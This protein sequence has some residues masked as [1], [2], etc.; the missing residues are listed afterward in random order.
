MKKIDL[1]QDWYVYKRDDAFSLVTSIP[2]D[3]VLTD[4]PYDALFHDEQRADSLNGGRTGYFDSGVYYYQKEI[5]LEEDWIG[6]RLLLKAEG[7]FSKS[8]VYVNGSLAG[9]GDFG[10]VSKLC[11]ITDYVIKGKNRLLVVTKTDPYSSRW[12]CGTGILRPLYLLVGEEV[13]TVPDSL[14]VKTESISDE[15]VQIRVTADFRKDS[16]GAVIRDVQLKIF[17][18]EGCLL[19]ET[20]PVRVSGT[21]HLDRRFFL[22]KARLYDEADPHLYT[23]KLAEGDDETVLKT[24][25]RL[26]SFDAVHGLC[27]NHK[28]VKLRGACIHHDEGILGGIALKAFEYYRVSR[29]KEAGFNAIR[30][31]HNHPSQELL[32]VCDELGVYV[33]DEVCDMWTKMK[34]F[35]DYAQYFQESWQDTVDTMVKEDR[36]HPCVVGYS[37]GNEISDLNTEKGFETAHDLYERIHRLDDTRFVTNGINGAFAAG[38]QL[39]DIAVDLT[40]MERSVFESGD[41]NQFLGLMASRM[42]DI[43]THPVVTRVVERMDSCVDVQGYNYMT[44]RY[45]GDAERYTN[46]VMLGTETYPRQ[47]AEN[48]KWISSLPAVIG[49][50][51]WTGWDYMGELSEPYPAINNKAG[52][53]D[54]FGYRRPVSYY[55]EIVYGLRKDPY[56]AVRPPEAYGKPRQFGPWKFTDAEENWLFDIADGQMVT[57]E[58]YAPDE[59]AELYLNGES[60]GRKP[61]HDCYALFDVPYHKGELKAVGSS[62]REYVLK[63]GDLSSAEIVVEDTVF[64]G[65]VFARI[66]LKDK[67]GI[68]I[69]AD[70][71]EYHCLREGME[72]IASASEKTVHDHGFRNETIRLSGQGGFAV[73]RKK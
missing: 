22:R 64:E 24:G 38:E 3:A 67:D 69:M 39:I 73:Y 18:Q 25:F 33:L 51:T 57:V 70:G 13:Y 72:L 27:I 2:E 32:E 52:D 16:P 31:A 47:I 26:E 10:Y 12:Y 4:I 5:E 30:S 9:S 11:D 19:D 1:N 68:R 58:V 29:L 50:F 63:S 49:D 17:D 23:V 45:A 46:R 60:M 40:G 55:R 54:R 28:P 48:W 43:V 56:I 62:G 37:T 14:W 36:N 35:G 65:Y 15:G 20:F 21:Y 66:M 44:E 6:K 53:L 7:L 8:F 42:E 59:E 41:V 34:G 71:Q 61:L